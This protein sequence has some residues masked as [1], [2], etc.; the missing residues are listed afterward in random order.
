MFDVIII[1][2]GIAAFS[3]ALFA[4]RRGLSVLVIG[5]D[6]AGQANYTDAIENYPGLEET[7]GLDLVTTIREQAENNG[8]EFLQAEVQQIKPLADAFIVKA[9]D[10]Q[11]KSQ[12]AILAF[13]KT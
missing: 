10:K 3:A 13:G 9:F 1:G 11:Y 6:L 7:G 5:K 8:A 12:A 4:S 2:G